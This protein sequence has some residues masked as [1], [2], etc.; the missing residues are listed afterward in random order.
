MGK[1]SG[2]NRE[3]RHR[4]GWQRYG[5]TVLTL[6]VG[7]GLSVGAALWVGRWEQVSRQ[8]QF[9]QQISN[10]NTA[11]QRSLN[12]YA[13]LLLSLGDL[14]RTANNEVSQDEFSQFVQRAVVSYPGI[15]ALEWAP[16]IPAAERSPY[17]ANPSFGSLNITERNPL[18]AM[19]VAAGNRSEYFPVTY[20]EPLRG[21]E[22]ALGYDLASDST[23]RIALE[24]ARDT[25]KLA[26]TARI[27]L[28]QEVAEAQYSFLAFLPIYDATSDQS[29]MPLAARRQLLDGYVLGVFR[30]ADVVEEAL[31]DLNYDID[32]FITDRTASPQE[33]FLGAYESESQQVISIENSDWQER[34]GQGALCP[35]SA[36][37][38]LAVSFGQ[39]EWAILFLPAP[40]YVA[41]W[42][43]WGAIATLCIGF[44]LTVGVTGFVWRSQTTLDRTRELSDL[45]IRFFSMASHELR[46]PLSTILLTAQSLD[47]NQ[48]VLSSA[49]KQNAIERIHSSARR[50]TQLL[51]DILTLTRA[52]AERLEFSPEIVDVAA[53]CNGIMDEIQL[54][55]KIGQT[56]T[57]K[58]AVTDPK[59]YLDKKLGRSL[60][61]NLL[62]NAL[63]YSPPP[64]TIHLQVWNDP[65]TLYLQIKDSG[66]GIPAHSQ[67]YIF[68][69]FYRGSNVGDIPGTGLGLAVVKTCVD[70]HQGSI[71]LRSAPGQ[72]TTITIGLPHAE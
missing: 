39:R 1:F 63:K 16:R 64:S 15:Q 38:T 14:Y 45:K 29:A 37:C 24:R 32:F 3:D 48:A 34:L 70:C 44:L 49:Q 27:R 53:F 66:I 7:I 31:Q 10:L 52:E 55:A 30:V 46:T 12:R 67:P 56:L 65:K 21:N 20:I 57:T 69:A 62:A 72:G 4:T 9:Q 50:M 58:I 61:H 23:R 28:V 26:A 33:Q 6:C 51:N 18:G 19:V 8:Q 11:L 5:S 54:Q 41:D 22:V 42:Q 13:E 43:P 71:T 59:A 36:D 47:T 25:G 17:E 68:E 2:R 35:T 60:L 40:N